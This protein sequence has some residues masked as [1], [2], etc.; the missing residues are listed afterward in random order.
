MARYQLCSVALLLVNPQGQLYCVRELVAKPQIGKEAGHYSFPWETIE[1]N[2][3]PIRTLHRLIM[4][5]VDATDTVVFA[6]PI[7]VWIGDVELHNSVAHIFL[8][9]FKEG[10]TEMCGLHAGIEIDP[11][12]WRSSQFLLSHCR[13]GVPEALG[14]WRQHERAILEA[15][16]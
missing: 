2:E 15:Q 7:P 14:L 12:G 8:A 5:E 6:E 11:L 13:D 9:R 1:P 3:R 10:P 4:E 16:V